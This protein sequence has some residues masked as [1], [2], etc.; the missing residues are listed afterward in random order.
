[1]TG[2]GPDMVA[3]SV[4]RHGTLKLAFSDGLCGEVD[5]LDRMHGPMLERQRASPT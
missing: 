3:V 5:V 2:A 1:M 4:I